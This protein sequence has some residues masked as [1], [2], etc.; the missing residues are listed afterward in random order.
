VWPFIAIWQHSS[1]GQVDGIHAD[2]VDLD[3]FN[4][5][6]ERLALYG[7]PAA[8]RA[9]E[10][11]PVLEEVPPNSFVTRIGDTVRMVAAATNS[12]P[13]DLAR[14]N[15]GVDLAD[16]PAGTL[17]TLPEKP[18]AGSPPADG[19]GGPALSGETYVTR[20]FTNLADVAVKLGAS[21]LALELANPQL[22]SEE[23]IQPGEVLNVPTAP[24]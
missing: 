10:P 22:A 17:L 24:S 12:T 14:S 7:K 1:T 5:P 21:I 13:E 4:G 15:A 11:Q 8:Q 20:D 19:R 18:P 2:A 9:A 16:V 23:M 3:F 6:R